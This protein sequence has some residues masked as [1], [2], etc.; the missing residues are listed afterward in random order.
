[1]ACCRPT[2][3]A[4]LPITR[5]TSRT[6]ASPPRRGRCCEWRSTFPRFGG[7]CRASCGRRVVGTLAMPLRC[8]LLLRVRCVRR[9]DRRGPRGG[10]RGCCGRRRRRSGRGRDR[11]AGAQRGFE[12]GLCDRVLG[13]HRPRVGLDADISDPIRRLTSDEMPGGG[14][15]ARL[16]VRSMRSDL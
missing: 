2:R 9:R 10:G 16:S 5:I 15:V 4:W 1:M 11:D 7:G 14:L 12:V 6:L 13:T 3:S 8:G